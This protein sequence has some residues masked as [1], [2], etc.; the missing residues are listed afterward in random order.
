[1]KYG[2]L[3]VLGRHGSIWVGNVLKS[4]QIGSE[5]FW[6]TFEPVLTHLGSVSLYPNQL[7][8]LGQL[9]LVCQTEGQ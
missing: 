6:T 8:G 2:T 3:Y 9:L 1:M 5:P 7:H 4:I